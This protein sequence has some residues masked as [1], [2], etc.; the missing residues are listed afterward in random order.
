MPAQERHPRSSL[1]RA[2]LPAEL[3]PETLREL[4]FSTLR[5]LADH[6]NGVL[7]ATEQEQFDAAL[8]EVMRAVASRV[9]DAV[10]RGARRG[11]GPSDPRLRRSYDRAQQRLAEQA[12]R[13]EEQVSRLAP[14]QPPVQPSEQP[15]EQPPEQPEPVPQTPPTA[16]SDETP[17]TL[18]EE[19]AQTSDTLAMLEK[20]A[21]L[22]EQ[23][24]ERQETQRLTDTRGFFFAFLVSIAV[25]V[26]GIAPL[27]EAEPHERL[28]I[29]VW[30]IAVTA[31]AGLV[32]ALIRWV[33]RSR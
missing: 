2:D 5:R 12:R 11:S 22:E 33:Q 1:S 31:V 9:E 21:A 25:I 14:D 23:Q 27:V 18:E 10:E 4:S 29:V 16:S 13:W 24:L 8:P 32:Y 15:S 6:R 3:T 20:I 19:V 28:L 17:D 30:T 7:D 26:A